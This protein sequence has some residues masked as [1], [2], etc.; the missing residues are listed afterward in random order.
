[1]EDT[2]KNCT[3]CSHALNGNMKTEKSLCRFYD[4]KIN[5][6][7]FEIFKPEFVL[8]EDDIFDIKIIEKNIKYVLARKIN[9]DYAV[10]FYKEIKSAEKIKDKIT[11]INKY[12]KIKTINRK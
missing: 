5:D 12:V 4:N 6:C 1:M 9:N 7:K 11:I 2:N 3:M 8:Y 10:K